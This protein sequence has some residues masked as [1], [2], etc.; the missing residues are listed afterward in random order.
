MNH[1]KRMKLGVERMKQRLL[2][3]LNSSQEALT[4]EQL[5]THFG[6][7][8]LSSGERAVLRI[9]RKEGLVEI[10]QRGGQP[11]YKLRSKPEASHNNL[12]KGLPDNFK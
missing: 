6:N 8:H 10:T 11:C 5:A 4:C 9:V 12:N 2:F 1:G 3:A 7:L